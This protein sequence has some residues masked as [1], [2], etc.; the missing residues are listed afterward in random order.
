MTAKKSTGFE[1]G[2]FSVDMEG[3][4]NEKLRGASLVVSLSSDMFQIF[5]S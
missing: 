5:I 2:I 4:L 1:E 3:N